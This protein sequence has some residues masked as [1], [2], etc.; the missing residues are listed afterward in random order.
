MAG[1]KFY[2][3]AVMTGAFLLVTLM[4]YPQISSES[5][6]SFLTMRFEF[7]AGWVDAAPAGRG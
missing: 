6:E 7:S 4:T 5:L 2:N 3:L 1:Y